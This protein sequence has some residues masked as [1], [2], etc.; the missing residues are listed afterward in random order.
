MKKATVG[1]GGSIDI[2]ASSLT[3][4]QDL[5]RSVASKQYRTINLSPEAD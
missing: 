1:S 5:L 2:H 3:S 4:S